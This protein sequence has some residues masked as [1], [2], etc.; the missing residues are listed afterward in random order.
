MDVHYQ[1]SIFAWSNWVTHV[2]ANFG[3]SIP[4]LFLTIGVLQPIDGLMSSSRDIFNC[5]GRGYWLININMA[6][7]LWYQSQVVYITATIWYLIWRKHKVFA[8]IREA[9]VVP[10]KFDDF[11]AFFKDFAIDAVVLSTHRIVA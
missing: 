5:L 6:K 7:W 8:A 1:S 9:L 4:L 10:S 3:V 2:L 11:H